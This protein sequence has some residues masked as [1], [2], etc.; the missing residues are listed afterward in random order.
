MTLLCSFNR[1]LCNFFFFFSLT[2]ALRA[3]F[4]FLF[5]LSL[6]LTVRFD[7]IYFRTAGNFLSFSIFPFICDTS[8]WIGCVWPDTALLS[9]R[10]E[11][12]SQNPIHKH[13]ARIFTVKSIHHYRSLSGDLMLM[14]ICQMSQQESLSFFTFPS[15]GGIWTFWNKRKDRNNNYYEY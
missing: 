10:F 9:H 4:T 12:L 15:T 2:F 5:H 11:L 1:P 14:F 7:K 3:Q 13:N 6:H 8:Q